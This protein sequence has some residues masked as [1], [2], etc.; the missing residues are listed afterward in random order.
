MSQFFSNFKIWQKFTLSL[1]IPIIILLVVSVWSFI[2]SDRI[3]E[4]TRVANEVSIPFALAAQE[5]D[6]NII[7]IQQ[8]LTDISATRGQ[9]GLNDGFDEA[10]ANYQQFLIHY[11]KFSLHYKGA[12]QTEQQKKLD[13][14]K[15][16]V[17]AFYLMGQKM[18]KAYIAGGPALGNKTMASFDTA[19]EA[20][21]KVLV[22]FREEQLKAANLAMVQISDE[23]DRFKGLILLFS[24][25]A[26]GVSLFFG[27][28]TLLAITRPL[29]KLTNATKQASKEMDLTVQIDVSGKDEVGQTVK[30]FQTLLSDFAST[31]KQIMGHTDTLSSATTELSFTIS[32]IQMAAQ[33]VNQGTENSSSALVESTTNI[34]ELAESSES[35]INRI[36]TM[37]RLSTEAQGAANQGKSSMHSIRMVMEKIADSSERITGFM[38]EISQIGTQTNLLSLNASIEAAKAGEF[39]KGFAVVAEEVKLL[40]ERSAISIEKIN[41]LIAD[42]SQNVTDGSDVINNATKVFENI[43][44]QVQLID[45]EVLETTGDIED[46][47]RRTVETSQAI[48]EI[49]DISSSNAAAMNQLTQT[50]Y[51][52]EDTTRELNHMA[53]ELVGEIQR[54]KI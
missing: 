46:Q 15:Q 4:K 20:L 47:G 44:A 52:V 50:I 13:E 8:W 42:S 36:T 9:D 7:Q 10:E 51:Q 54:F 34:K 31:I 37:K 17:D 35:V 11:K 3:H 1:A 21:S 24:F 22:P 32:E 27:I 16:R 12:G 14:L 39:G 28:I 5:M 45:K 38:D 30:A 48:D 33:E 6:K 29:L 43:M 2:I 18:A 53:E 25:A 40:S 26:I 19:A 49:N 23:L 41:N